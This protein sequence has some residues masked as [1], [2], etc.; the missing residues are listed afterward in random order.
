MHLLT[1]LLS[2]SLIDLDGTFFIQFVLFW[3]AFFV[4][5]ATVFGPVVK[6]F[7]AR[8]EE[9]GGAIKKARAMSQEAS[10]AETEFQEEMR[11][12]RGAASADRDRL[13]GE[14]QKLEAK[15]VEGVRA[16]TQQ[17]FA[18]A[19]ATLAKEAAKVRSELEALTPQLA[20][21]IASKLLQREVS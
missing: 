11:K 15:L 19:D 2:G 1:V 18:E 16:E 13:R 5:K 3:V 9:I 20:A 14:G 6:L 12:A 17:S 10:D 21:Q 4:L 8:E 7:E